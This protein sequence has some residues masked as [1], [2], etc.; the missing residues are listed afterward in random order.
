MLPNLP[1]GSYYSR[2][3]RLLCPVCGGDRPF[4]N[5]LKMR[6][7][8][9]ACGFVYEREPGYF[10]GSTYLNYGTTAALCAIAWLVLVLAFGVKT[11]NCW[12]A[13]V[14][15]GAAF[16]LWFFRYARLWWCAFDLACDPPTTKDF[17]TEDRNIRP[18][19]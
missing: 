14:V 11:E 6:N 18:L 17:A 4:V 3:I 10:L 12:P 2:A 16:P 5:W 15:I 9:R 13:W 7:R 1:A 19:E 8:C